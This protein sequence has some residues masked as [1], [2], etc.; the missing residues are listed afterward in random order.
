M[1][2]NSESFFSFVRFA[3]GL[4]RLRKDKHLHTT[5]ARIN[6]ER[7]FILPTYYGVIFGLMLLVML[8][9]SLNYDNSLGFM[10]TFLLSGLGFI[11]ILHTYQNIVN[12]SVRPGRSQAVFVGQQARFGI[13]IDNPDK[14][15]RLAISL[16]GTDTLPIICD[17]PARGHIQ[18]F[19]PT[20]AEK[21]GRLPM[22]IATIATRYP[23]GLYRAWSYVK[24]DMHCL[25][26]PQPLAKQTLSS[27]GMT[28]E[29]NVVR[30]ESGNDDFRGQRNYHPGDSIRHINWKVVAR[31]QP[32]VTKQFHSNESAETWLDWDNCTMNDIEER[33]SELCRWVLDADEFGLRYGMRIPGR[34]IEPDVG[35]AHKHRCLEALALFE[36]R[37]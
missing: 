18:V 23:L 15:P 8:L 32:P 29:G 5:S 27:L 26:Y 16:R 34:V 11:A 13:V 12:I 28:L 6:R 36:A 2:N 37:P 33:L 10:L 17:V 9:G 24:V 3:T 21:R 25:V 7:L 22:E 35:E 4:D 14:H 20:K 31:A 19:L 1:K 30:D